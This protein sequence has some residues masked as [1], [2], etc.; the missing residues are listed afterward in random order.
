LELAKEK[1]I[2]SGE[3]QFY[4][5]GALS[6]ICISLAY[7][8][9]Q[10]I[11]LGRLSLMGIGYSFFFLFLWVWRCL[12]AY[13]YMLDEKQLIITRKGLGLTKI[14]LIP[15]TSIASFTNHYVRS[16]FRK[17]KIG[18]YQ[19]LY[20][21]TDPRPQRLL[22]YREN[23]KLIGAIFKVSDEFLAQ[24]RQVIPDKFIDFP[25]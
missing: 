16:F 21:S 8:G 9:Y 17:T 25:Q 19:H 11:I 7:E 4:K 3:R 23:D 18:K 2:I 10:S 14:T 6:L 13:T 15:L 1:S 20:S 12:F 22:V 5:Y 24:V